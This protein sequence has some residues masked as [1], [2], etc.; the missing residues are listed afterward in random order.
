MKLILTN[1]KRK[2]RN[3]ERTTCC[4]PICINQQHLG[5]DHFKTEILLLSSSIY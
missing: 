4:L 2:S 5:R 3:G 1:T